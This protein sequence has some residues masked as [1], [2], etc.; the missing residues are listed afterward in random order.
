MHVSNGNPLQVIYMGNLFENPHTNLF[1]KTKF[2][3]IA[4]FLVEFL[5]NRI[6][7]SNLFEN[8][9]TN[10]FLKTKFEIIANFLVEFLMN[11]I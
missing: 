5:M 11:R 8:S 6:Y 10:L 9:H 2:E 7:M 4:N 1:L 3:I